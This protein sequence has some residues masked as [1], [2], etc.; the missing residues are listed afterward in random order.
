MITAKDWSLLLSGNID[1]AAEEWTQT[2]LN[3]MQECIPCHIVHKRRNLLWLT[4][5]VVRHTK[6]RNKMFQKAKKSGEDAHYSKF[7]KLCYHRAT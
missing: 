2:F 5:S 1:M 4:G 3:I 7:K 6:K